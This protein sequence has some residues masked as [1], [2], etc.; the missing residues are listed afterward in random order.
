ML[1]PAQVMAL[2]V[3]SWVNL[4]TA[5]I[6]VW[7]VFGTGISTSEQSIEA[8]AT[9]AAFSGTYSGICFFTSGWLVTSIYV[10]CRGAGRDQASSMWSL[11]KACLGSLGLLGAVHL[12][13]GSGLLVAMVVASSSIG[14]EDILPETGWAVH[15]C[16]AV[17]LVNIFLVLLALSSVWGLNYPR[18]CWGVEQ[19][20]PEGWDDTDRKNRIASL[21]TETMPETPVKRG[22]PVSL[23][24]SDGDQSDQSYRTL[25]CSSL[26]MEQAMRDPDVTLA[27]VNQGRPAIPSFT[28]S[29]AELAL[30]RKNLRT[31]TRGPKAPLGLNTKIT[32]PCRTEMTTAGS[33][34]PLSEQMGEKPQGGRPGTPQHI[35]VN[36]LSGNSLSLSQVEMTPSNGMS[37]IKVP[38][39]EV[40]LTPG[41]VLSF[42]LADTV[43]D[44]EADS[45][46]QGFQK[47]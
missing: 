15:G 44:E 36:G 34:C 13:I 42:K 25:P 16:F 11:G 32:I 37:S 26:K 18:C 5:A 31:W 14:P 20:Q 21:E 12:L 29:E 3:S 45:H 43:E 33:L 1:Y 30:A 8:R 24:G 17:V 46:G 28:I 2:T 39:P 10:L 47:A 7:F 23:D 40:W 4:V 38:P 22:P 35:E 19:G 27:K 9:A 6:S 41:P